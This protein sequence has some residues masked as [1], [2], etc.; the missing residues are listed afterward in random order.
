MGT[1]IDKL[2][3]KATLVAGDQIPVY[4]AA[5][6][7]ARRI[8]GTVLAAFV[9]SSVQT[10]DNKLTQYSSPATGVTVT[11]APVAAGGSVWLILTP[12][13]TIAAL[14][15]A[16]PASGAAVDKQ[17]VLVNCTQIITTLTVSATGLTVTGAPTTLATANGFFLMRF[18][19]VA[20][21]WYR[22]G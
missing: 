3:A 9:A 6:G 19:A 1:S 10:V 4:S 5:D 14:T 18:D 17:E 21:V 20:S 12:T 7:D 2:S 8:S 11:I 22:V 16:L 15:I 13:G